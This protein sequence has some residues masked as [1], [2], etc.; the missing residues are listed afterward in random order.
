MGGESIRLQGR[1]G[2]HDLKKLY[3]EAGIPPWE[4]QRI[5]LIY[6][7]DELVAVGDLWISADFYSEIDQGCINFQVQ[8]EF[9]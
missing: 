4:R 7:D 6:L 5:P 9:I 2:H 3:Q 1:N 8:K